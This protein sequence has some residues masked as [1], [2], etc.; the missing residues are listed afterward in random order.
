L[1]SQFCPNPLAL[2][3]SLGETQEAAVGGQK[4]RGRAQDQDRGTVTGLKNYCKL[5]HIEV[6]EKDTFPVPHT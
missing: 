4:R 6:N 1:P 2:P 5:V 3:Q